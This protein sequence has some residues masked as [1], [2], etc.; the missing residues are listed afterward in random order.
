MADIIGGIEGGSSHSTVVLV[1]HTG[2]IIAKDTGPGTNHYLLGMPECWKRIAGMVNK[3]KSEAGIPETT[4]IKALGLS[5]SGCENE[6]TNEE[7]RV[8]LFQAYPDLTEDCSVGSDTEG[9]IAATSNNGGVTC[10]A[11]TGSNTLLINPDGSKVQCGGYGYMVGDEGSAWKIAHTAIKCCIDDLDGFQPSPYPIDWVWKTTTEHFQVKDKMDLMGFFY[12]KFDKAFIAALCKKIAGGANDGDLL[13][14]H[15]FEMAGAHI[16][17]SISAVVPKASPEL[18]GRDGGIHV[19][20]VGSVWLSWNLLKPGFV[21]YLEED[22]R[23]QG[24][25][26]LK[27]KTTIAVGA[28]FMACD[29]LGL[30]VTR[31]YSKNYEVF[32]KYQKCMKNGY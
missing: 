30:S 5:L 18:V 28:A 15:I 14:K 29:K 27:I 24:L 9:S 6:E 12:T 22:G 19:L 21:K 7:L 17:R 4:R 26:L 1:D 10:I 16:A 8:G 3:V 2:K 20:C 32:F 25:S 13:S 11:G 23:V 31:D